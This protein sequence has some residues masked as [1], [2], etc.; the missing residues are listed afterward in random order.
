MYRSTYSL[1]IHHMKVSGHFHVSFP[2]PLGI[3]GLVDP[4]TYLKEVAR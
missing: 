2:V 1:P 4:R 3:G